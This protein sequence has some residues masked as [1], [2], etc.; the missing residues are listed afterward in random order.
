MQTQTKEETQDNPDAGGGKRA[1]R[2][3][4]KNRRVGRKNRRVG[5]KHGSLGA[6]NK[7]QN[8]YLQRRY[9][10]LRTIVFQCNFISIYKEY[11]QSIVFQCT[12]Q[13]YKGAIVR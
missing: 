1:S 9:Y 2:E 4:E 3:E 12:S 7:R 5:E 11:L 8:K 10:Q 6:Q 13:I